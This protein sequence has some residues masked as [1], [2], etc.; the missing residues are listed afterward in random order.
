MSYVINWTGARPALLPYI[1]RLAEYAPKSQRVIDPFCGGLDAALA[2]GISR[3]IMTDSNPDL[4]NYLSV[5]CDTHRVG[6][7]YLRA[8]LDGLTDD[9]DCYRKVKESHNEEILS[10]TDERCNFNDNDFDYRVQLAAEFWYLSR[11]AFRSIPRYNS[12]GQVTSS[13][14]PRGIQPAV[15]FQHDV[16]DRWNQIKLITGFE[17]RCQDFSWLNAAA[18]AGEIGSGDL[19]YFDPPF[20]SSRNPRLTSFGAVRWDDLLATARVC[21]DAGAAVIFS[22]PDHDELR[23]DLSK[24]GFHNDVVAVRNGTHRTYE[25]LAATFNFKTPLD[26]Y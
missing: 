23:S 15:L 22:G 5:I 2:M 26:G 20:L 4:I 18:A 13:Y 21:A 19:V 11:Y 7:E 10:A 8:P 6:V 17:F 25:T 14:G 24:A 9:P 16:I 1:A 3:G 12:S